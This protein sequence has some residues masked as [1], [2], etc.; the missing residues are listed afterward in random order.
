MN[1]EAVGAISE[2]LGAIAVFVTLAYL[3][4]Q[5][6]HTRAEMRRSIY[7][8]RQ[9]AARELCLSR[10][11]NEA[12][13]SDTLKAS[14]AF[15]RSASGY[16]VEVAE[17]GGLTEAAA[18]RV[19]WDEYAWWYWRAQQIPYVDELPKGE[20]AAFEGGI[21]FNYAERPIGRLW[22]ETQ[23]S[24]LS[25]DLVRYVESVLARRT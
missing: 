11:G 6:R 21:R 14:Q 18:L 22:F 1:W 8:Q 17:R 23:K 20:R 15:G 5:V 2:G 25:P 9:E 13:L 7:V 4:V 16:V 19:M 3:A 12:L 24:L 10:A